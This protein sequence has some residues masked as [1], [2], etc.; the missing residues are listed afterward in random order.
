MFYLDFMS[1]M[2]FIGWKSMTLA[3]MGLIFHISGISFT[4]HGSN[5]KST[6]ALGSLNCQGDLVA[7]SSLSMDPFSHGDTITL[8]FYSIYEIYSDIS[9]PHDIFYILMKVLHQAG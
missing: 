2:S 6:N 8:I 9:Q 3:F 4:T 5:L 1:Y 7:H